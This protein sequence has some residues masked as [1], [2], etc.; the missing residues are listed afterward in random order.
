MPSACSQASKR[1]S[2]R[3]C[4][5]IRMTSPLALPPLSGAALGLA[6]AQGWP[7]GGPGGA[8]GVWSAMRVS[9]VSR[10]CGAAA[11][12]SWCCLYPTQELLRGNEL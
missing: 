8:M 1:Q 12:G 4:Y 10:G 2:C 9:R 6:G 11:M 5:S 3:G 7:W